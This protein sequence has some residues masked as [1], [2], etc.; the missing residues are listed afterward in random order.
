MRVTLAG[1][2]SHGHDVVDANRPLEQQQ[3][4]RYKVG[5]N[6]LQAETQKPTVMA[7]TSH[8]T[9]LQ[10]IPTWLKAIAAA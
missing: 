5:E 3:E 4:T 2:I 6:L 10:P 1:H 7:A 8:R 9:L